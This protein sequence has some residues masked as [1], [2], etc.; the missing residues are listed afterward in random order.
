MVMI[1]LNLEVNLERKGKGLR[2]NLTKKL[3]DIKKLRKHSILKKNTIST[4][5]TNL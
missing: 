1:S 5:K 3:G 4:L 2:H